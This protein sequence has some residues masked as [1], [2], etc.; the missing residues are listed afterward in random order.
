MK[1]ILWNLAVAAVATALT[2]ASC[3]QPTDVDG[4]TIYGRQAIDLMAAGERY[5]K[6]GNYAMALDSY[7]RALEISPRPALYYH[8]GYC[9]YQRSE[10]TKAQ[11]YLTAAVR[12]AGDYPPAEY[13]L[14][15]VRIQLALAGRQGVRP[16]ATPVRVTPGATPTPPSSGP[17]V[18]ITATPRPTP[19]QVAEVTP[20]RTPRVEATPTPPS[21]VTPIATPTPKPTMPPSVTVERTPLPATRTP[22]STPMP[23]PAPFSP[24]VISTPPPSVEPIVTPRPTPRYARP[25]TT[26]TMT[27][28]PPPMPPTSDIFSTDT[29]ALTTSAAR[30]SARTTETSGTSPDSPLLGQWQFHWEQAQSF[31]D[32]K[33][34]QEAVDELLLVLGAQ[35]RHL[36]ARLALA[37]AYDRLGRGEKALVEYEKGRV[38]APSNPK[39]YFR[40]GN[41]YLR[42]AGDSPQSATSYYDRARTYYYEAINHDPKYYFAHHNIGITYMKQG[43]YDAARKWLEKAVEIKPD[44]A[45][46]HRNLGILF[47]QHLKDPKK[48]LQYYREYLRLG[49]PDVEEVR[50][51]VRAIEEGP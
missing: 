26:Q 5:E 40:N 8:I 38:F 9:Y 15:K 13:L 29:T 7:G 22:T 42:H 10:F 30:T 37:D 44:Y 50:E 14:S 17:V 48:A 28:V 32:R 49:G 20:V 4:K 16:G 24:P 34:D 51:W 18:A 3:Q 27:T 21:G 41:Y 1:T 35:P 45:S 11:E 46:A 36:E 47:E 19:R 23:T 6:A 43:N 31:I 2:L 12:L 33:M 39:P 25:A